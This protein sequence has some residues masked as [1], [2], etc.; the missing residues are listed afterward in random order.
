M[1]VVELAE[2]ARQLGECLDPTDE[3]FVERS[4]D[5][6]GLGRD[7]LN[8]LRVQPMGLREPVV[9]LAHDS[10]RSGRA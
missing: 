9:Q 6:G 7:A 2:E 8:V 3:G 4:E 5:G 10:N 1:R